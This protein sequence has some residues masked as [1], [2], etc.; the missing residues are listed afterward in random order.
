LLGRLTDRVLRCDL[1]QVAA[2]DVAEQRHGGEDNPLCGFPIA[3]IESLRLAAE[4]GE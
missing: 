4:E 3:G 2:H 1:E